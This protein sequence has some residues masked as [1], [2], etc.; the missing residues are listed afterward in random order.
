MNF[1]HKNTGKAFFI[2]P[3]NIRMLNSGGILIIHFTNGFLNKNRINRSVNNG[4]RL[5]AFER[6]QYETILWP[7]GFATGVQ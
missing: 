3:F 6:E 1:S 5:I 4:E 2:D 7:R